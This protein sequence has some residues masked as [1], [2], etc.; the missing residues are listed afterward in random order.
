MPVIVTVTGTPGVT[1]V[2]EAVSVGCAEAAAANAKET[3]SAAADVRIVCMVMGQASPGS[4]EEE[5]SARYWKTSVEMT[6]T[7]W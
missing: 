3:T 5:R 4:D 1:V 6:P 7:T 2:D